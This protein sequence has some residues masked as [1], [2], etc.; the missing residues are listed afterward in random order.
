MKQILFIFAIAFAV[1][2]MDWASYD[3]MMNI[4]TQFWKLKREYKYFNI[5]LYRFPFL[6]L[7][8]IIIFYGT[9]YEKHTD[10]SVRNLII[11]AGCFIALISNF[12]I[13]LYIFACERRAK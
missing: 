10:D 4:I 9:T 12:L 3:R 6:G 5:L 7:A 11:A 1:F 2:L 13:Y 8:A